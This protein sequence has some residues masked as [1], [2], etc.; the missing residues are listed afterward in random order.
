MLVHIF[1]VVCV[2]C[3][4]ERFKKEVIMKFAI[5]ALQVGAFLERHGNRQHQSIFVGQKRS[6]NRQLT[7]RWPLKFKSYKSIY[8]QSPNG[9]AQRSVL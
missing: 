6:V 3:G 5:C 4:G 9:P 7:R 1:L 2:G 8:R